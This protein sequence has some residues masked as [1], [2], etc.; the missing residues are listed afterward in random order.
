MVGLLGVAATAGAVVHSRNGGVVSGSTEPDYREGVVAP[1]HPL[2][3]N[4]LLA[5]SD[6]ASSGVDALLYRGL[7]KFDKSATPVADLATSF[8]VSGDGLSYR[9]PLPGGLLWS[10]GAPL[11]AQDVLATVAAVQAPGFPDGGLAAGWKGVTV[12][13]DPAGAVTM[14]LPGPRASFAAAVAQLPI[15]PRAVAARTAAAQTA[16]ATQPAATSGAYRV[17]SSDDSHVV[18]ERNPHSGDR[19]TL[20]VLDMTLEPTFEQAVRDLAAGRVDA[21]AATSPGERDALTRLS[22]VQ[23]QDMTSFRFVDVILNARHPGLSDV[24]VRRALAS[25]V[26]RRQL[27]AT[28]LGGAGRPQVDAEPLGITWLGASAQEQPQPE[29]AARALDAA[30]WT[31][32]AGGGFRTKGAD[33]LSLTLSVPDAAPLPQ[34]ADEL[35]RQ[36]STV[37]V[38]ITVHRVPPG[39]VLDG[40]LKPASFDL[41][42]VD[43]DNGPDPDISSFWRS[44]AMPP[45][46]FNVSGAPVDLF[47]DR[48]LDDLAT[49]SDAQLRIAAAQ[50]VEQRLTDDTPAIFL[51]SPVLSLGTRSTLTGVV[52]PAS[53]SP[54]DRYA[55]IGS[56]R[57]AGG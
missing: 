9:F 38:G 35:A 27:V 14:T 5:R 51:Y 8:G 40:T 32:P 56:W 47:L 34:V 41:A 15:V 50:R 23:V 20:Q 48:A 45:A 30:G 54:S 11:T 2:T 44:N 25:A 26:D 24:A 10:D 21:V 55:Q 49:E 37:G 12:A 42:L 29:L 18:L 33:K 4:P 7:L 57:R 1:H 43:W 52:L 3:L 17:R 19:L 46:G 53:G 31:V 16:S 36:L 22:G 28:A 6:A 13:I 39:S